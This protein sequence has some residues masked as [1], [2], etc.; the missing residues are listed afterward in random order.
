ME[1]SLS[2]CIITKDNEK[3]IG[4]CISSII[5]IAGEIIIADS[6][7]KD[8]TKEIANSLGCKVYDYK[9]NDNFSDAKNFA[10]SKASGNWILNLDADETISELDSKKI[11]QTIEKKNQFIGYYLIQRNY[12]NSIGDFGWVSSKDDSYSESKVAKGYS[13]R[14][15]LR[16]FRNIPEIRFEGA[17]HDTVVL[18]IERIGSGLI[19]ETDIVIHHYGYLNRSNERTERYIEIEKKNIR[20]DYFQEFQIASQ[21]HSIGKINDA[22][23]HL[24]N[25]IKLNP[26][27]HASLLLLG[28]MSIKKGKVS[29]AKP[30]LLR[31]LELKQDEMAWEHLGIVETYEKNFDKAIACFNKAIEMNPKNADFYF[32]LGNTLKLAGRINQAKQAYAKAVYLNSDYEDKVKLG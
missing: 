20:N 6:G 30:I 26:N 24:A 1:N 29:E 11:K 27:F 15:M 10:V 23:V 28:I 4:N 12:S 2:V 14:K 21:L 32:N 19:G 7:S 8:R 16:L 9:W 17:V 25:S 22:L 3:T 5:G 31:S 13:P 18:S